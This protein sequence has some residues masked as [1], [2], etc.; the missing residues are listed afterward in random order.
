MHVI[1]LH[2]ALPQTTNQLTTAFNVNFLS[3]LRFHRSDLLRMKR[4]QDQINWNRALGN[5]REILE[6][7]MQFSVKLVLHSLLCSFR[8]TYRKSR[9]GQVDFTNFILKIFLNIFFLILELLKVV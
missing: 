7:L 8:Y 1:S 4:M 5:S 2:I 3:P 6:D 9:G